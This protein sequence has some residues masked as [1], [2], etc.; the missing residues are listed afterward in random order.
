MARDT[1]L[2]FADWTGLPNPTL[3]GMYIPSEFAAKK[4]FPFNMM[5]PV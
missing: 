1:I 4:Y 5:V 2:V 3:M